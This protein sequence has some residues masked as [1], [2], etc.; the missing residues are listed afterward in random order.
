VAFV[1][2]SLTITRASAW[3]QSGRRLHYSTLFKP[4]TVGTISGEVVRVAPA[5]FGS[6]ADYCTQAVLRTPGGDLSIILAPKGYMAE[7][8]LTIAP[9]DRLMVTGSLISVINKPFLLVTE[10]AGDRIMKLREANGRPL[11]AV[12]GDWQ[13]H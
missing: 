8:G 3:A 11:W 1:L 5:P 12:E 4:G 9:G 2:L 10:V 7:K 6:G 13:V